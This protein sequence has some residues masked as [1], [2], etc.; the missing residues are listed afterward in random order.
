M[1]SANGN[2]VAVYIRE[3]NDLVGQILGHFQPHQMAALVQFYKSHD[4][5]LMDT[6]DVATFSTTQFVHSAN[7]GVYFEIVVSID[8]KK[9]DINETA[10]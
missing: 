4:T 9:A 6:G 3:E 1:I 5:Y 7:A 2:T 8:D 10:V